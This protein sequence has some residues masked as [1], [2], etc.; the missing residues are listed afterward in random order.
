MASVVQSL[1]DVNQQLFEAKKTKKLSFE[2]I[3][4]RM[5]RDEVW[6]AALFYGQA[7]PTD[8][9]V[10][11]LI[12]VLGPWIDAKA[13]KRHFNP[14]FFP[15]RGQLTP[16]PP[17]DPTLYRLYEIIGVYG[18]ALKSVIHEKFGDGIMSAI[19]FSAKVEKVQKNGADTVR[20]T[21]EGKWLPYDFH[22]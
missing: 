12:D 3:A 1:A 9:E 18:Y 22:C 15:E 13:M 11:K 5:G 4:Q 10:D 7:K 8:E 16:M 20:I 14:H 21:Y 6:V 2:Q 19:N 17:T